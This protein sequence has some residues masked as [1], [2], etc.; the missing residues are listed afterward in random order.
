MLFNFTIEQMALL[1][2]SQIWQ[3]LVLDPTLHLPRNQAR[4]VHLL[5]PIQGCRR[6]LGD[7]KGH[8][9]LSAPQ[10]S[11]G[12]VVQ[13]CQQRGPQCQALRVQGS[14]WGKREN[15]GLVLTDSHS[16]FSLLLPFQPWPCPPFSPHSQ[17]SHD[18]DHILLPDSSSWPSGPQA[19]RMAWGEG[20]EARTPLRRQP[21][22]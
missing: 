11:G 10:G 9:K 3:M 6:G 18:H 21:C 2:I 16:L 7:G 20:P 8:T 17:S 13:Q 4:Q 5:C 14:G 12:T 15:W 19:W 22:G 1:G